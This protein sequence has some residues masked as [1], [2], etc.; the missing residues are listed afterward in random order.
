MQL[1]GHVLLEVVAAAIRHLRIDHQLVLSDFLRAMAEEAQTP[2]QR[3]L[4]LVGAYLERDGNLLVRQT[5]NARQPA[6]CHAR[7]GRAEGTHVPKVLHVANLNSA[8][9][10]T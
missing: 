2:S 6:A 5:V 1:V 8:G 4:I 7:H 9:V 10:H 3:R